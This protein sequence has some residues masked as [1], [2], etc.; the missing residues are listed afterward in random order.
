MVKGYGRVNFYKLMVVM[1]MIMMT[2]TTTNLEVN[3]FTVSSS[4]LLS[5]IY[6]HSKIA[7]HINW[8]FFTKI[9]ER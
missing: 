9:T 6:F 5:N 4:L 7:Y 3:P 2:V 1:M 8:H